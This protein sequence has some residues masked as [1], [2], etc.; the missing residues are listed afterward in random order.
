METQQVFNISRSDINHGAEPF[1][2]WAGGKRQLLAEI[3][4][5]IPAKFSNYLEPFLGGGAAFF[6]LYNKNLLK[7]KITL[8][9]NNPEL[10][11]AYITIKN[12]VMDLLELLA[13]FKN[14]YIENP[15]DF[16]YSLR[17]WDRQKDYVN[18][19]NIEKAAR[20]IFLNKTCFNGLYRVNSRGF[21]N[22]PLGRYKNPNIFNK[23]NLIAVSDAL[24]N[25]TI[26]CDDFS[27]CEKIAK[28]GDFIYFDPPYFP[29][30]DTSCFTGYT[31]EDFGEKE[32]N[33][34]KDTFIKLSE[35][36][37]LVMLSNSSAEFIRNL[38]SEFNIFEVSAK[39]FI[40]CVSEGR[41]PI[42]EL[43]VTNY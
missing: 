5:H 31:K 3:E 1:L 27:V 2:K 24:K 4:E 28:A 42:K 10:I 6:H 34:L 23:E 32:Q 14:H 39:R 35:A 26:L 36:G 8:I 43:L 30:S 29:I 41:G 33:K 13:E 19:N 25:T 20:T 16:Y 40:N 9:D 37:C 38:Y 21:F 18:R 17:N 15:N 11:N 7:N 12:N 22:V